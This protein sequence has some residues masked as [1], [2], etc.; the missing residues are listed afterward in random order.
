MHTQACVRTS[1][2]RFNTFISTQKSPLGVLPVNNSFAP[3]QALFWPPPPQMSFVCSWTSNKVCTLGVCLPSLNSTSVKIIHVV[4]SSRSWDR[5]F[6][7]LHSCP[8]GVHSRS[9]M[10]NKMQKEE[11]ERREGKEGKN[12]T[13]MTRM[14]CEGMGR[15]QLCEKVTFKEEISEPKM[16]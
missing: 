11:K 9:Y 3:R 13:R 1:K 2:T 14:G 4:V 5:E 8:Q 6:N 7:R 12:T 16:N 15:E 10:E